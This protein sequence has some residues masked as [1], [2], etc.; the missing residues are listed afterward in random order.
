MTPRL[1]VCVAVAWLAGSASHADQAFSWKRDDLFQAIEQ[2][3]EQARNRPL[4]VVR[5]DFNRTARSVREQ[6]ARVQRSGKT[7]PVAALRALETGQ[8]RLA[9]LAAAHEALLPEAHE[10]LTAA[11]LAVLTAARRWPY[12]DA[13]VHEQVYR[14]IYGGRSA[15]E[16]ALVQQRVSALPTVTRLETVASV[17]PSIDIAGVRVHSGD[18]VLSRGDAAT[19]ALIARGNPFPANFS[20][21]S[22]IHVDPVTGKATVIESLIEHGAVT[23]SPSEFLS[24]KKLRMLLL[25]MRPDHPA[26]IANP[27]AAH[28]AAEHMLRRVSRRHVP[29]DFRMDWKNDKRMF[30]S[31]IVYHG[32]RA[33]GIEVWNYRATLSLPGL[34]RWLGDMGVREFST[35]IPSDIEYDPAFMPVAEWRNAEA[36]QQDRFDNV[37]LDVL[38]EA[39]ERGDR[40]GFSGFNRIPGSMVKLWSGMESAVGITPTIPAGMTVETVL[41]VRSLMKYVHPRLRQGIERRAQVFR[42][43]RGY[44]PPYWT[45]TQM[46]R[47]ELADQQQSLSPWLETARMN[48]VNGNLEPSPA[49]Q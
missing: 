36:L 8:F 31:E 30:C 25:R 19:S 43:R 27:L 42:D 46:A 7:V 47:Q 12:S 24:E 21:V 14:V 9:T 45:L 4:A 40:L 11:R 23:R 37:T 6:I 17:A 33:A 15:I 3:F 28:H 34:V 20:H 16:E 44:P 49:S 13:G 10:L 48:G 35:L 32:Y 1:A 38:L 41:R 2:E 39:A 29:Y 22:M 5:A 26:L 18:I